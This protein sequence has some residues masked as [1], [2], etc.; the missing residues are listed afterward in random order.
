M[1]NHFLIFVI[2]IMKSQIL[3]NVRNIPTKQKANRYANATWL[4]GYL[5]IQA[6]NVEA[7]SIAQRYATAANASTTI[8]TNVSHQ[9]VPPNPY[10]LR[11]RLVSENSV[12]NI[13]SRQ[14][15]RTALARKFNYYDPVAMA[16]ARRTTPYG[17]T[18]FAITMV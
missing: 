11:Q 1:R 8:I 4:K 6:D 13:L 18:D 3:T 12:Y 10:V 16:P 15:E 2:H 17:G 14:N 9:Y 5:T 7:K